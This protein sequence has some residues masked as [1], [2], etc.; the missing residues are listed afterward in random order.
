M[1]ILGLTIDYG[2]YGWIDNFDAGWTPNTTDAEGKRYAFG[3]QPEIARWNLS[4][5]GA[6]LATLA[7]DSKDEKPLVTALNQGLATFDETYNAEIMRHFSD[8]FGFE[9]YTENSAIN[10]VETGLINDAFQLLTNAEIDMTLFFNTLADVDCAAPDAT[11]FLNT[12]YGTDNVV[13]LRTL[14]AWLLRYAAHVGAAAHP[15]ARLTRMQAANPIYVLRNYLAQQAIDK[16]EAGDLSMVQQ[17][18]TVLK[19]PYTPQPGMERFAQKR[20]DWARNRAGC[21][22]LSCSS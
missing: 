12:F 16:A 2:P 11:I 21:S 9:I 1:S 15:P 13:H 4:R 7:T 18:L 22:M 20:P 14:Q 19:T 17:L 6:A 10:D 3:R 5:L 8:K